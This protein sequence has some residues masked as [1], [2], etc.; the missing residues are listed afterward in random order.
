MLVLNS[1]FMEN[2]VSRV[3][4]SRLTLIF[5]VLFGLTTP[6][7]AFDLELQVQP[8]SLSDEISA[9]SAV[10]ALKG[11]DDAE[12]I[13]IVSAARADYRRLLR[14]LYERAYY[15]ASISIRVDGREAS[16]ISLLNVSAAVKSVEI[17]INAREPFTFSRAEIG[18]LAAGT[19]AP[20]T[21]QA[22]Q[23]AGAGQVRN[24]ARTAISDWRDA[25]HAKAQ[26]ADQSIT[27]NHPSAQLS[28]EI[29][30]L[31]GP[32]LRFGE[33]TVP[34]DSS[35]RPERIRE[36][37]G[38]PVGAVF[39]PAEI[40]TSSQR[41]R[42]TGAFRSVVL[43][44]ADTI[45]T[46]DQTL[47]INAELVDAPPRRIG[48]GGEI[49]TLDG[50]SLTAFWLHRNLL[51][52]AERLRFDGEISGITETGEGIDYGL[53][54]RFDRP[55]TF[56][57]D[58]A[59]FAGAS[60]T[61]LDEPD[62]RENSARIETGFTRI[63]NN[64]LS[65]DIAI[66]YQYA[67]VRDDLGERELT[68]LQFPIGLTYDTRN[69]E[70][71]ATTGVFLDVDLMPFYETRGSTTGARL[72]SDLRTYFT[73][74]AFDRVTAALRLQVGRI[75]G[76]DLAD[77]TPDLLFFS[78]GAGT[79]RGQ[80]FQSLSVDLGGGLS[81]GGRAFIGLSGELRSKVSE[82]WSIVAFYD[83]GFIGEDSF[84]DAD[85][86]WHYGAGLGARYNTGIGPIRLDLATP[87][88]A[89]S[90]NNIEFYIGIGQAF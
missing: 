37:A 35:V 45:N 50:L 20:E 85:G 23:R 58:T 72:Y 4:V 29:D 89:G 81:S 22:S 38:L 12:P 82:D 9:A 61:R 70:L 69:D 14:V 67:D 51:G 79:V 40:E 44:E 56:A 39:S 65:G 90:G 83:A 74:N 27:A 19:N 25:G 49:G 43:S 36:I 78:G 6:G 46:P 8:A 87:V 10:A 86:D 77:I 73:P 76:G 80:G 41:L 53:S 54:V 47:D 88:G 48:F 30:V 59:F 21:F 33:L 34:Q 3:L 71:N 18:P 16:N 52:G 11:Q 17:R 5:A 1:G 55:A 60:L 63:F 84:S 28:V 68:Y 2:Q 42:R 13:D 24:A 64:R 66:A 32:R 15:G 26:I 57:P 7:F 75:V 31:P 62:Y